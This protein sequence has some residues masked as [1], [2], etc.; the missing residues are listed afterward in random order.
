M[1][2]KIS[3]SG[4]KV[5]AMTAMLL[6]HLTA[7]LW[8]DVPA[9]TATL[10]VTDG[11]AVTPNV[12]LRAFG[13]LAFPIFAFL[14]AE[15][16]CHTGNKVRYLI[17][18]LVLAFLSEVPWQLCSTG[19]SAGD[20]HNVVFT[21]ALGVAV[22]LAV[23]AEGT[24]PRGLRYAVAFGCVALAAYGGADYGA[25]G[26]GFVVLCFALRERAALRA[27]AGTCVLSAFPMGLLAGLAFIPISA[28][29]GTRGFIRGPW[30]KYLF[31]VFYPAHLLVI[32]L[33][34]I[35]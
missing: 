10:F 29:D 4:L 30:L 13:R 24:V 8:N 19:A 16:F 12:L 14:V 31:Y 2:T 7:Y 34:R 1:R 3:G 20:Y 23:T 11:V 6:D 27:V 25:L 26:V 22:L 9:M 35:L 15:G 5:L 32:Y 33:I 21:L 17:G 28:Y 18:L